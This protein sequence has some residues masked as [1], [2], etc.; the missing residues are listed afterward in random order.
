M[1]CPNFITKNRRDL[2]M[3]SLETNQV[4]S[5]NNLNFTPENFSHLR[6]A[7]DAVAQ[8]ISDVRNG[9]ASKVKASAG[10]ILTRNMNGETE[11]LMGQ[12]NKLN[13]PKPKDEANV[14]GAYGLFSGSVELEDAYSEVPA[15]FTATAR[16]VFEESLGSLSREKVLYL[17]SLPTTKLIKNA[18]WK[19]FTAASFH[20]NIS[21]E[22]SEKI[23]K[24][25]QSEVANH[26]QHEITNLAWVS[27][28]QVINSQVRKNEQYDVLKS[29]LEKE[30]GRPLT[31]E[32]I[33]SN[34]NLG[35]IYNE[36][37]SLESGIRVAHYVAR[38]IFSLN[39]AN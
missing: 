26:P 17:L 2:I 39:I 16:E 1:I 22:E 19:H 34:K 8:R 10:L 25:F 38:T 6:E 36:N 23:E 30:L 9:T 15:V 11:I 7:A 13:R 37:I 4:T 3:N 29:Q 28:K 5:S 20:A 31:Q 21:Q 32:E 35:R 18:G 12:L 27:L 33:Q 14:H 24:T